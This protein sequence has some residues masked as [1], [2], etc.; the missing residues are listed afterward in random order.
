MNSP[1]TPALIIAST[2]LLAT[3]CG[4]RSGVL[5]GGHS[6]GLAPQADGSV[7]DLALS[8]DLLP[9]RMEGLIYQTELRDQLSGAQQ[10]A[11]YVF[12][13]PRPMP[14]FA[15]LQTLPGGC[16]L[17]PDEEV[18]DRQFSAGKVSFSGGPYSFSL[19][20]EKP[21]RK[22]SW[23]YP[24]ILFD[25]L[26]SAKH[27]LTIRAQGDELPAFTGTVQ[28][29]DDLNVALPPGNFV[30]RAYPLSLTFPKGSG[31]VWVT[32]NGVVSGKA[33]GNIRCSFPGGLGSATVEAAVLKALPAGATQVIIS[34]GLVSEKVIQ[35][36]P[37][38]TVHLIAT[39]L[40][41]KQYNL[42]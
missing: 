14:F 38:L 40:L 26:F 23:L 22:D 24:G 19:S 10:G 15:P 37:S 29:V 32:L 7:G 1:R 30:R 31:T 41:R 5:P 25:D 11:A 21:L 18:G 2:L 34:A 28:G 9:S 42:Q 4:G 13:T 8:P 35:P 20:P 16:A 12:F 27:T 36:N 17:Y 39:N 3:A 6:D 33:T